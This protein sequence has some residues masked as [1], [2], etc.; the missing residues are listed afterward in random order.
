MIA[1]ENFKLVTDSHLLAAA[2]IAM[3]A[4][5]VFLRGDLLVFCIE[6]ATALQPT[7]WH[8]FNGFSP[9]KRFPLM[10]SKHHNY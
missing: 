2:A 5:L 9:G 1:S 8:Q 6:A 3:V 4:K 7:Q 10:Y